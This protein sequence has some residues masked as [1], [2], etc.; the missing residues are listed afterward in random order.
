MTFYLALLL[1]LFQFHNYENINLELVASSTDDAPLT[2]VMSMDYELEDSSLKIYVADIFTPSVL[3]FSLK[4]NNLI[5]TKNIGQ[6]GKG[7][8]DFEDVS[9][10]QVLQDGRLLVYDKN[11]GRVT[12]FNNSNGQTDNIIN[13]RTTDSRY[14][15]MEVYQY[16]SKGEF[17]AFSKKF[18][19]ESDDY[20]ESRKIYLSS[21]DV[22][23]ALLDS[24]FVKRSNDA[25]VIIKNG[26]M[27][28]NPYPPFGRKSIFRLSDKKIFYGWTS[29]SNIEIFTR[30]GNLEKK[31]NFDLTL[32]TINKS[33][34]ELAKEA[35]DEV[36]RDAIEKQS[37]DSWP[38]YHDFHIDD[39]GN[40]WL[41]ES[42]HFKDELRNLSIYKPN[43]EQI[44]KLN[45]PRE[46]KIFQIKKGYIIGVYTE[47]KKQPIIQLYKI[48]YDKL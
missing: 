42:A 25:L 29:S 43:G 44:Q 3:E 12:I 33:D 8:G 40:F 16:G 30:K 4:E 14:F 10:I 28:V 27:A 46:F 38:L 26:N 31:I 2:N 18:F 15:P 39:K 23:G 13:I 19:R 17:I 20:S 1:F 22:E 32:K 5:F 6:Y 48:M 21:Y 45:L 35:S 24:I 36:F 41:T 9:N 7:P 34:I 11:L 47:N 37:P